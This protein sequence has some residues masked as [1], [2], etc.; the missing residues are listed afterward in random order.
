MLPGSKPKEGKTGNYDDLLPTDEELHKRESNWLALIDKFEV[1]GAAFEGMDESELEVTQFDYEDEEESSEET[2]D[3][4]ENSDQ[5]E[6]EGV[7]YKLFQ[8]MLE[9]GRAAIKARMKRWEETGE[10]F[11]LDNFSEKTRI[12]DWLK[13]NIHINEDT[14]SHLDVSTIYA[15][16]CKEKKLQSTMIQSRCDETLVEDDTFR[17]FKV[18]GAPSTP[19]SVVRPFR[20]GVSRSE[21]TYNRRK[22]APPTAIKRGMFQNVKRLST[23]I[24]SPTCAVPP[25][26]RSYSISDLKMPRERTVI[27]SPMQPFVEAR[28][29]EVL[30][31]KSFNP[32]KTLVYDP[33]SD[34]NCSSESDDDIF[35]QCKRKYGGKIYE[36]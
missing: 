25:I 3:E 5:S 28:F 26:R 2:P 21:S 9:G 17:N 23:V 15:N 27:Y 14:D 12:E 31:R 34:A 1:A 11:I 35:L 16:Q 4:S 18:S 30:T 32:S 20:Q 8:D 33:P 36:I 22:I 7:D 6:D 24:E 13:E 19:K 10:S 29:K